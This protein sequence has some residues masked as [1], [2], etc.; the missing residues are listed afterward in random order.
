MNDVNDKEFSTQYQPISLSELLQQGKSNDEVDSSA[1]LG[2]LV[3]NDL[4]KDTDISMDDEPDE[5][6]LIS[7]GEVG[8][9]LEKVDYSKLPSYEIDMIKT[10]LMDI[11]RF[12]LLT[13]MEEVC[14]FRKMCQGDSKAKE[15]II[16]SNYRLV[17]NIAKHYNGCGIEFLDLIQAGNEGLLKAVD[18]FDYQKGY[19]FSTYATWWIRQSITRYIADHARLIRIPV[20][21]IETLNKL[22]KIIINYTINLGRNASVFEISNA[23]NITEERV[24]FL[25]QLLEDVISLDIPVG[26]DGDSTLVEFV[27]QQDENEPFNVVAEALLKEQLD[28]VLE[29]LKPREKQVVQ[30]RFG[31]NGNNSQTLEEIGHKFGV[32]RER[33]RQIEAKALKKLRNSRKSKNLKEYLL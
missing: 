6:A 33:I 30:L 11:G 8:L 31:L 23:M 3:D 22:K 7:L 10:Y 29:T 16:N 32:T 25:L 9:D 4:L 1:E 27:K 12:H 15:L 26:E 14:F 13:G 24:E 5:E 21:M 20:H 18:K 17:V 19:K 28:Q 2:D